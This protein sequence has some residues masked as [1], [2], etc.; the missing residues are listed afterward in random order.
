M[1]SVFH[2]L[3]HRH[4]PV[5]PALLQWIHIAVLASLATVCQR[6]CCYR[7]GPRGCRRRLSRDA[8]ATPY[9]LTSESSSS[10]MLQCVLTSAFKTATFSEVAGLADCAH[11][12]GDVNVLANAVSRA[13]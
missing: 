11:G 9:V 7:L 1:D 13:K 6:H 10:L 3:K 8:R 4:W 5:P 2:S 12:Y